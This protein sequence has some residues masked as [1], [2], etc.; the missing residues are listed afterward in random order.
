MNTTPPTDKPR[1]EST[2]GALAKCPHCGGLGGYITNIVYKAIRMYSW[3]RTEV[4]TDSFSVVSETNPR[5]N[6]CGKSVRAAIAKAT[7][8]TP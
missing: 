5:C 4:D 3:D 1:G 6:D 2:P 8:A 7:G